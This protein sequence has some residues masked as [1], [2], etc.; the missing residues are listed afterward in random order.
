MGT[1]VPCDSTPYGCVDW[2]ER[3]RSF[4]GV[5]AFA[6]L[7]NCLF[8]AHLTQYLISAAAAHWY[9]KSPSRHPVCRSLGW[10][11]CYHLGSIAFG[12]LVLSF[13]A[14]FRVFMQLLCDR[15]HKPRSS[16]CCIR[17]CDSILYCMTCTF[18]RFLQYVTRN[19][20]VV[21]AITG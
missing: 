17:C 10:M 19:A 21:M 20:Y 8:V 11:I 18:H 5:S 16:N 9:Y 7:W 15:K 1:I 12:S 14:I 2:N 13:M 3:F 6:L 4:F